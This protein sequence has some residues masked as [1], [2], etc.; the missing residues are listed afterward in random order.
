MEHVKRLAGLLWFTSCLGFAGLPA[1][2]SQS[3]WEVEWSR[4]SR[5]PDGLRQLVPLPDGGLW[6]SGTF[7]DTLAW[8]GQQVVAE[9]GEDL[10]LFEYL[11][12]QEEGKAMAFHS[13]LDLDIN[14]LAYDS[15]SNRLAVLGS[16]NTRLALPDTVLF[17]PEG[18]RS[19]FVYLFSPEQE[20]GWAVSLDSRGLKDGAQLGW[21][22]PDTLWVGGYF[23]DSLLIGDVRLESR[24]ATDPFLLAF[25]SRTGRLLQANHWGGS[26]N[27]RARALQVLPDGDL[28]LAGVLDDTLYLSDTVI[29]AVIPGDYDLFAFRAGPEGQVRWAIWGGGVLDEEVTSLVRWGPSHWLLGGYFSGNLNLE[30]Q[31]QLTSTST[32]PDAY[33]LRFAF[34]GSLQDGFSFGGSQNVRLL[35]MAARE[36]ELLAVG[37]FTGELILGDFERLARGTQS[38]FISRFSGEELAPAQLEAIRSDQ[39]VFLET[40]ALGERLYFAGG[41]YSGTLESGETS[42]N[43]SLDPLWLG[44]NPTTFLFPPPNDFFLLSVHPNPT[45]GPIRLNRKI[46]CDTFQLL[47]AQGTLLESGT[48]D[49]TA[50]WDLSDQP[51]GLYLLRLHCQDRWRTLRI[52]K[53]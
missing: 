19:L 12:S 22:G 35:D 4:G 41:R 29:Q 11:P 14:H 36:G 3:S 47:S 7:S 9:G 45:R 40:A 15:A 33:L 26:G 25:D 50:S 18:N 32:Q 44:L 49:Q 24:G 42:R 52:R 27:T 31:L 20:S 2:Y 13:A 17:S 5:G 30:P 39:T 23:G 43:N 51:S 21:S 8:G 46:P 38:G 28:I 16:Y 53:E 48:L 34:D 1:T 10:F 37:S 6:L